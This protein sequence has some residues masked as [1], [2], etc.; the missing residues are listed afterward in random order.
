MQPISCES[1]ICK[2]NVAGVCKAVR[3]SVIQQGRGLN[4]TRCHSF[5]PKTDTL[6]GDGNHCHTPPDNSKKEAEDMN[7]ALARPSGSGPVKCTASDCKYNDCF[8]CRY[9]TA[10]QFQRV[11][12]FWEAPLC[13]RYR[14]EQKDVPFL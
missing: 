13:K 3:V 4:N 12:G 8:R 7:D 5:C 2:H 6:P 10:L 14:R 9:P 11:V 1:A